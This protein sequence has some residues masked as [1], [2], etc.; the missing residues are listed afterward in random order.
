M[1]QYIR[2]FKDLTIDDVPLVGGK[3]ASLGEMYRELTSLGVLVP[4]GFA[5]TVK[6]YEA[7]LSDEHR[8]Q[9]KTLLSPLGDSK[10]RDLDQLANAGQQARDLVYSAPLPADVKEEIL[11]SFT[12]LKEEYGESISVAVRSSATAE[13]LP[14][15]SFAGQ[16]DTF[17][18]VRGEAGLLD[19]VKRCFA[20][21]FTNRAIAYRIDNN[22][23]HEQVLMSV[24]IM[25]M[26][27]SDLGASGV[28][29][30]IDSE[31]GFRDV[32][33]ITSAYG[34][35]ETVVQGAVEVDEAFV[36]VSLLHIP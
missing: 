22:Y 30:S 23:P 29:F 19:A 26:V 13:D 34:L 20:S 17:L 27:R 7:M 15:S 18:N 14:Q 12:Q 28:M 9:L 21:L 24:G 8:A 1:S 6:G 33:F 25:K 10:H 5:I 31:T 36:H 35:G 11:G 16:H 32:V 2:W 3:N 4:N